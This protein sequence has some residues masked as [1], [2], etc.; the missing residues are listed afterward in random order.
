MITCRLGGTPVEMLIDS[1]SNFNILDEVT[2]KYLVQSGAKIIN[3]QLHTNKTFRAYA[4]HTPLK[5]KNVFEAEIG[6]SDRVPSQISTF[7]VIE[8]GERTLLGKITANQLGVLTFGVP[9]L[10]RTQSVSNKKHFPKIKGRNGKKK[11]IQ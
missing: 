7:Y 3:Q 5:V 8:K 4:T 11:N 9:Q 6:V 10:H 1:G 2:W